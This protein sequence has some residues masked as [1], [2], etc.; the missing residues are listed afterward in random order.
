MTT[1]ALIATLTAV[2]AAVGW[3]EHSWLTGGHYLKDGDRRRLTRTPPRILTCA[4]VAGLFAAAAHLPTSALAPVLLL[5]TAAPALAWIDWDVHRLPNAILGPLTGAMTIIMVATSALTGHWHDLLTA[6]AGAGIGLGCGLLL[7][8]LKVG[9][10]A[11]DIKLLVPLGLAGG[12]I[13]WTTL[14]HVITYALAVNGLLLAAL[15]AVKV[16]S[17]GRAAM[18]PGLLLGALVALLLS[19]CLPASPASPAGRG[20]AAAAGDARRVLE[21]LPVR[22]A[23]TDDGYTRAWFGPKYSDDLSAAI[24]S[25]RNGCDQRNDVRRRD[26]LTKTIRPGTRGCVVAQGTYRDPYTGAVVD[27][28]HTQL[29]HVVSLH[30]A[31]VT[32]GRHLPPQT[33]RDLAGD[34]LNLLIISGSA[35]AS[36]RESDT[37]EPPNRQ[38]RCPLVARQIAVKAKYRLWVTPDEHRH[39]ARVLAGCP[40]QPLPT[41]ADVAPPSPRP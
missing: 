15:L 9:L 12:W 10:G 35:N 40:A 16:I 39:M 2:G 34:P 17:R 21:A 30:A 31:Y 20:A 11:G 18:G 28:P 6:L 13:S 24:P 38:F 26:A 5:A 25:A 19:G 27:Q 8:V 7:A 4:T 22:D 1:P 23:D 3:L 37:W 36:K 41:E 33:R 29:E 32:G 14:M